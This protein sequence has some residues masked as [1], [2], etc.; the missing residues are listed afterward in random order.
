MV[1]TTIAEIKTALHQQ[2]ANTEDIETLEK[3]KSFFDSLAEND[4]RIV[5][6]SAKLKPL[7]IKEY[8]AEVAEAMLLYQRGDVVTQEELEKGL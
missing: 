3:V 8:K 4:K 5:A 7:T 6:Y 1:M 2:V